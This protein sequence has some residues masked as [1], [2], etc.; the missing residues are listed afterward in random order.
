MKKLRT[1]DCIRRADASW[2]FVEDEEE[3]GD[4]D[5]VGTFVTPEC[6]Y[7]FPSIAALFG[8]AVQGIVD[9]TLIL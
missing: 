7:T 2:E 4:S 6:L 5:C 8:E 9:S 1:V 3:N